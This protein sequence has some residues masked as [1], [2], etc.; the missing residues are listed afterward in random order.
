MRRLLPVTREGWGCLVLLVI[1]G[2]A[3]GVWVVRNRFEGNKAL[4][5]AIED[6]DAVRVETLLDRGSDPSS[7]NRGLAAFKD[8][9]SAELRYAEAPLIRAVYAGNADIVRMLL[10]YGADA[11]E[12][13]VE[14]HSALMTAAWDNQ[15]EIV[16]DL[17]VR[18]AVPLPAD[19]DTPEA[20]ARNQMLTPEIHALLE[21]AGWLPPP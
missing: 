11:N 10:Q 2:I 17:L 14:G 20:W 15:A 6:G 16:G 13:T 4:Y 3:W 21:R 7:R 8:G 18:G 19:L 5:D 1:G 9:F 12:K